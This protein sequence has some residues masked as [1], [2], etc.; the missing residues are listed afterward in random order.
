M[1]SIVE[2]AAAD[3]STALVEMDPFIDMDVYLIIRAYEEGTRKSETEAGIILSNYGEVVKLR[4]SVEMFSGSLNQYGGV[5]VIQPDVADVDLTINTPTPG[6]WF[7]DCFPCDGRVTLSLDNLPLP[8]ILQL[9][10]QFL[11]SIE[12]FIT[13]MKLLMDP[14]NYY[15]DICRLLDAFRVVCPQDIIIL[16]AILRYLFSYYLGRSFD[17][18][19]DW[20]SILAFLLLPLLLLIHGL[21]QQMVNIGL[22][23]VQCLTTYLVTFHTL[24]TETE[25]TARDAARAAS[26]SALNVSD[27]IQG[28]TNIVTGAKDASDPKVKTWS[29]PMITLP[30]Q[31]GFAWYSEFLGKLSSL[32]TML[33]AMTDIGITLES[34]L[35][36][37]SKTLAVLINMMQEGLKLRMQLM[38]AITDIIRL[39][40]FLRALS[41]VLADKSICTDASQ[42]LS[43]DDVNIIIAKMQE[44]ES[45]LPTIIESSVDTATGELVLENKVTDESRRVPK[46]LS[47]TTDNDLSKISQWIEDL[48]GQT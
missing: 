22:L 17:L 26:T 2:Q 38:L 15:S 33:V 4:T 7:G 41:K 18:D 11:A 29:P 39:V 5:Q 19:I 8:N 27:L 30:P 3:T 34:L 23:P 9:Y 47:S 45:G 43:K 25:L 12:D 40:A 35:S 48:K 6:G 42:P 44:Q 10:K 32:E 1:G 46:C 36:G 20:T 24:L 13:Q 28:A 16:L 37:W 14:T 31:G 21:L